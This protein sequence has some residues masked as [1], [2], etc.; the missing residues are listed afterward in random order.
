MRFSHM[1][2]MCLIVWLAC[3]SVLG[4]NRSST[5]QDVPLEEVLPA[6]TAFLIEISDVESL[7]SYLQ[8]AA[9]FN[10]E[11]WL[12]AIE[13]A[14]DERFPL[15]HADRL[16]A[17]QQ[18]ADEFAG[19]ARE[20]ES[21]T[22]VGQVVPEQPVPEVIALI[23]APESAI[24]EMSALL[25]RL[26]SHLASLDRPVD[27]SGESPK[28]EPSEDV[29]SQ[30]E[31][32]NSRFVEGWWVLSQQSESIDALEGYF[33]NPPRR[34][35]K[36]SRKYQTIMQIHKQQRRNDVFSIVGYADTNAMGFLL[37]ET[38]KD[39]WHA[40]RME[41]M[42]AC[43]LRVELPHTATEDSPHLVVDLS[44]MF[45]VP[46]GGYGK[47]LGAASPISFEPTVGLPI[48]EMSVD[49]IDLV[50]RFQAVSEI[51]DG[52]ESDSD[53][54]HQKSNS[55]VYDSAGLEKTEGTYRAKMEQV[56]QSRGVDLDEKLGFSKGE[57]LLRYIDERTGQDELLVVSRIVNAEFADRYVQQ[58]LEFLNSRL[59]PRGRFDSQPCDHGQL[60]A[61]KGRRNSPRREAY[62]YN[63]QWYLFGTLDGV[64]R[65]LELM[66]DGGHA[67]IPF[68]H[69]L[70]GLK[71]QF[72]FN[73]NPFQINC[74]T[75]RSWVVQ[76]SSALVNRVSEKSVPDDTQ[77]FTGWHLEIESKEDLHAKVTTLVSMAIANQF[78]SQIHLFSQEEQVLRIGVGVFS[79]PESVLGESDAPYYLKD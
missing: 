48:Y 47:V 73:A 38:S 39:R 32:L 23:K 17:L 37:P 78:G 24:S 74:Y 69:Q 13:L 64:Q 53:S 40:M 62:F 22:L 6:S 8:T 29:S 71:R 77:E 50:K 63:D 28:E 9:F 65:Q 11:S 56:Y 25:E 2:Q 35:L 16:Q 68:E 10:D 52:I 55:L 27:D 79:S 70:D 54:H 21:L 49:E 7:V 58:N 3:A 42:P 18:I 41:E 72:G 20:I 61:N 33:R 1:N 26:N 43:G 5:G 76:A 57:Y 45:T 4:V 44:V 34:P 14:T 19:V 12:Q 15:I 75:P 59:G 67:T 51:E 46:R 66:Y 31:R 30:R 60:F 36:R